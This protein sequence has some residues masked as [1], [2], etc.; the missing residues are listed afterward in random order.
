MVEIKWNSI[1][2]LPMEKNTIKKIIILSEGRLC[3]SESLHISTDYWHVF[4]DEREFKDEFLFDVKEKN[5]EN[6]YVYGKF[7]SRKVPFN[8]IKGWMFADNL[9]NLYNGK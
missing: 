6:H 4:V 5:D 3:D 1:N 8:K 7:I 2:D 9:I